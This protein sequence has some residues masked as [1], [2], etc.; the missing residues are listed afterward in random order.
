MD[1]VT[2]SGEAPEVTDVATED[3]PETDTNETTS[4]ETSFDEDGNPV[5]AEPSEDDDI[6]WDEIDWNGKKIKVPK[7]A[8]M[9][10]ADYTR[11]TQELAEQ[12]KAVEATLQEVQQVSE[13]ERTAQANLIGI[14]QAI[15][16]YDEIDWHAWLE[17]DPISAQKARIDLETLYST[18][19]HAHN[20]L[21]QAQQHRLAMSQRE[22]ATRLAEGQRYLAEKIQ[23]WSGDKATTLL[24]FGQ[25]YGFSKQDLDQ[26]TDPRWV[27][28]LNDALAGRGMNQRKAVEKK[29]QQQEAVKPAAKVAGKGAVY[30]GLDDRMSADA[31]MKARNAQLA[32]R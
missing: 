1:E 23:G 25:Q 30:R 13:A 12:R 29:V 2:N 24:N 3:A 22:T 27:V 20:N 9:M 6:D 5:E 31:W 17:Q 21:S 8:A 10:Q 26:I 15:A 11:K 16:Q 19:N 28:V 32:K 14:Q 7:G 4:E 18:A